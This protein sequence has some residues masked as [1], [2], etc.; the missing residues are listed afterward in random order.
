MKTRSILLVIALIPVS[1]ISCSK[2]ND[3][4]TVK[5]P[6][7]FTNDLQV[8]DSTPGLKS[9]TGLYDFYAS[10]AFNPSTDAT[11]IKYKSK[12]KS[13]T[14]SGISYTPSG[15]SGDVTVTNAYFTISTQE[16]SY[17]GLTVEWSFTSLTLRNG[18]KV[19]LPSPKLGTLADISTML[20]GDKVIYLTW[21][22]SQNVPV[23]DYTFSTTLNA[24]V[25]A[26]L[27]KK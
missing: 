26:Y 7:E 12:I 13:I 4:L 18:V 24:E 9:T 8:H 15:L 3:A 22:G 20:D 19:D 23:N 14:A 10:E 25:L 17:W 5:V 1:F 2:I 27:L 6:V 21:A 16:N 11:V